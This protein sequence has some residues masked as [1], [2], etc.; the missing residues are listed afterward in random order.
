M[1]L[2]RATRCLFP[3]APF[4]TRS[5]YHQVVHLA[6]RRFVVGEEGEVAVGPCALLEGAIHCAAGRQSVPAVSHRAR[7]GLGLSGGEFADVG[8]CGVEGGGIVDLGQARCHA[9]GLSDN[10][11]RQQHQQDCNE[12][13]CG[14]HSRMASSGSS[15]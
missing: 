12:P 1:P 6:E 10:A 9:L 11:V 13:H 15:A 3:F 14:F 5:R 8:H 7:Q 4:T 2:S